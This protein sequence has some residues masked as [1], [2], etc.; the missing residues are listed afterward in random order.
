VRRGLPKMKLSVE[1]GFRIAARLDPTGS[2]G[3]V[4]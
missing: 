4:R 1:G 2:Y 3:G